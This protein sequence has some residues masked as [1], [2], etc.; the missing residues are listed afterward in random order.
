MTT[1]PYLLDG[2]PVT[3]SELI[4]AAGKLHTQFAADWFKSTSVATSILRD[5][6]QEVK[7]NKS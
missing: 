6:G 1:K 7:G 5:N 2:E 3:A 4:A